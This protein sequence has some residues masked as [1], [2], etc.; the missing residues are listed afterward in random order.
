M[1]GRARDVHKVLLL[2]L[3]EQGGGFDSW[4]RG[5]AITLTTILRKGNGRRCRKGRSYITRRGKQRE[6]ATGGAESCQHRAGCGPHRG[7]Q[8]LVKHICERLTPSCPVT[9]SG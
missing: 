5:R 1:Q 6:L 3:L 9:K 7:S 8:R 2:W 4:V